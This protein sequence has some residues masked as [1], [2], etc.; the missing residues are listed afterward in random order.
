MLM[1]LTK[2]NIILNDGCVTLK[3]SVYWTSN[4]WSV[5]LSWNYGDIFDVE[6]IWGGGEII[7]EELSE[8]F[9]G[10]HPERCPVALFKFI[11]HRELSRK[12]P[13]GSSER[14]FRI[15]MQDT[16]NP[17]RRIVGSSW[18][19]IRIQTHK[20]KNTFP[21]VFRSGLGLWMKLVLF[22]VRF[23]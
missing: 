22:N 16:T 10:L 23:K 1:S 2:S 17:M 4:P 8:N 19:Q 3:W 6:N 5:M 18:Q 15:L 12:Y 21:L 9:Y 13:C 7:Y 20:R 11:F 14:R